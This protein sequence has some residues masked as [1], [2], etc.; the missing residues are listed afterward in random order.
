MNYEQ[1]QT[2]GYVYQS[3]LES[4]EGTT[5]FDGIDECI[6]NAIDATLDDEGVIVIDYDEKNNI[7]RCYDNGHGMEYMTL[8]KILSNAS[9]H[10]ADGSGVGIRG[11][12]LK[13]FV[14]IVGN[15]NDC[16]LTIT[17]STG[18]EYYRKGHLFV[19][20][21]D[22]VILE[23]LLEGNRLNGNFK[24]NG[25]NIF[26][27]KLKGTIIELK[28][29]EHIKFTEEI[30]NDYSVRYAEALNIHHKHIIINGV[31]LKG[32]DPT[33]TI[34]RKELECDENKTVIDEENRLFINTFNLKM[35]KIGNEKHLIPIKIT[36]VQL[37]DPSYIRNK[38]KF[39]KDANFNQYGG[40]Y[41]K[42]GGRFIDYGNNNQTM[43]TMVNGELGTT[44]SKGLFGTIAGNLS[45]Y[46]RI[47][48]DL[49]DDEAAK[50]F[51][52][53]SIKSKG[54][55]PLSSNKKLL[56]E[57]RVNVNNISLSVFEAISYLRK[58]NDKFYETKIKHCRK[59]YKWENL[60]ADVTELYNNWDF[61]AGKLKNK[62]VK[63]KVTVKTV[64]PEEVSYSI[65]DN[66]CFLKITYKQNI[67]NNKVRI[68]SN[69]INEENLLYKYVY[70]YYGAGAKEMSEK[71]RN[72]ILDDFKVCTEYA[73][74]DR[75]NVKAFLIGKTKSLLKRL[76]TK[77]NED[78]KL[79]V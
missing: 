62:P 20:P 75:E 49:K 3:F 71:I 13:K 43:F 9:Y 8:K 10:K 26:N 6:D 23:P 21:D 34:G 40:I 73:Y 46:N 77:V 18:D 28:N 39:E 66:N 67:Y 7:L 69:T 55:I 79:Y 32:F 59:G 37:L 54:I 2:K 44:K 45:G 35:Y 24:D 61:T 33:Y 48:I 47:I 51:G 16:V 42:R 53:Q 1:L 63:K 60:K 15:I 4:K 22:K 31:D 12:G 56:K 64:V 76:D 41:T 38:Y 78:E 11:V 19:C 25:I 57:Y 14:G 5:V 30:L 36:S 65:T 50:I 74:F 72:L 29:C 17:T 27:G 70:G 52:L 58:F 68:L